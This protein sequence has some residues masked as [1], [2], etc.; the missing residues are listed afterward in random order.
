MKSV[1]HY[2]NLP[3]VAHDPAELRSFM[4]TLKDA[5]VTDVA[6]N[7]L[8]DLMHPELLSQPENVYLW[9]ANYGP[10]LDLFVSSTLNR[11][12][13]PET[14][15]ARNRRSLLMFAE[16]AREAGIR[17]MLYLCEPR[18]VPERFFLR[19]PTLRG[20]RVD[21]PVCS[22]RPLFALCTDREEVRQHYREMLEK[23]MRLVPD[24]SMLTIF[25]SDSGSGF[26]YNPDN[27]AGANGAGFNKGIPLEVRVRNF[28]E[29]LLEVGRGVNPDFEVHLTSGFPPEERARILRHASPGIVGSVYGLYS[30]EGGL[31]D[32]WA[33]H[34]SPRDLASLDREKAREARKKDFAER[35]AQAAIG[36]REPIAH[37]ELPTCD[38]PRPLRYTPHPFETVRILRDL[39]E[40]GFQRI[41]P[42]GV[43]SPKHLVPDDINR[44]AFVAALDHSGSP[45]EVVADLAV[46]WVAEKSASDALLSAW[47]DCDEAFRTRPLWSHMGLSKFEWPGPMVPNL[48]ALR[49]EEE[50]YFMTEALRDFRDIQGVGANIPHEPD[51]SN[52]TYVLENIYHG[53]TLPLL[54]RAVKTLE[55]AAAKARPD[56]SAKLLRQRDHILCFL[57]HQQSS[58]NWYEVGRY[59]VP[60]KGTWEK[61]RTLLEIIDDEIALTERFITL[62]EG[63]EKQ[64]LRLF[65][66]DFAT[67]DLGPGIINQLRY[68]ITVMQEHRNDA[69]YPL[70]ERLYWKRAY[71]KA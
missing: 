19:H 40:I 37:A 70:T 9:F 54:T 18:F 50:D 2:P 3:V 10:P 45:E 30:W 21:N 56:V 27:Y 26:D 64:F 53:V 55:D 8:P 24:L 49:E 39:Q 65:F 14:Y 46:R 60:G 22:V 23:I 13:Y 34:Q 28:L 42:W 52:R 16:A 43:L 29:L 36:G 69:V 31:E 66:D 11:G 58:C 47:R 7:H 62:M 48:T 68:R 57:Y 63:R 1:V 4:A 67:Y 15:L 20:P 44:D 33:Y 41:S 6:I 12:L 61:G 35:F 71:E 17:P 5:R 59:L 51:E 32:H 25:T 38:Y